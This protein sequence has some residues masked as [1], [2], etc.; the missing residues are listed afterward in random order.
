M[1]HSSCFVKDIKYRREAIQSCPEDRPLILQFC[2]NDPKT[3]LEA[4]LLA[5]DH[6]DAIDINLGCPQ[7]IGE[8]G[9]DTKFNFH[10]S[11]LSIVVIVL[12]QAMKDRLKGNYFPN[13]FLC[14]SSN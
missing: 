2:G 3:V 6:C 1:F 11:P 4:A 12:V 14:S 13:C 5:Q 8:R 7:A 9:R 10:V